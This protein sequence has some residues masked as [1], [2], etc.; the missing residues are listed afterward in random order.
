MT[1]PMEAPKTPWPRLVEL[2]L[3][4]VLFA[5]AYTQRPLFT[6]NQVTKFLHGL[7][8]AGHGHLADD[9]LATTFNT[10][11]PFTWLVTLIYKIHPL[12]FHAAMV[13]I[14][15][16]YL[17]GLVGIA[18]SLGL[19]TAGRLRRWTFLTLVLA[20]HSALAV[21]VVKLLTG[22]EEKG[23][24]GGL[25]EQYL[26]G[27]IFQPNV[28]G[29]FIIAAIAAFASR[30]PVVAAALLA[31]APVMHPTYLIGAGIVLAV[32]L[33]TLLLRDRDWKRALA[34]AGVFLL[35]IV[36]LLVFVSINLA[37]TD[38]ATQARA[39]EILAHSRIE[40]HS[41]PSF[42]DPITIGKG[43]VCLLAIALAWRSVA[44]WVLVAGFVVGGALTAF[45][46]ITGSDTM[47][48]VAP[49]RVS[50]WVVPLAVG[51]VLTGLTRL[52][53]RGEMPAESQRLAWAGNALTVATCLVASV[54]VQVSIHRGFEA[55]DWV[56][57]MRYV[58]EHKQRGDLLM[59]PPELAEFRVQAGAATLVTWKSHPIKDIEVLA[60]HARVEAA[61]RFYEAPDEPSRE[62]ALRE[63][64]EAY[65]VTH[66]LVPA[67]IP[68]PERFGEVA[69]RDAGYALVRVAR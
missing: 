4:S 65:R 23:F 32:F 27:P 24:P 64:V 40:H 1:A 59:V 19:D 52:I 28:F 49:W 25:A 6:S 21:Q 16:F 39:H 42:L 38:A 43:V 15:A 11:P 2:L 26:I 9:W 44:G 50:V 48:L 69:Y 41:V 35:P 34:A 12:G 53:L 54:L 55:L 10:F 37:P 67:S 18:R 3:W 60:W 17:W 7:A 13:P 61:T 58:R 8:A 36:P 46:V 45:T 57:A 51:I 63:A 14:F 66:V 47:A 56:P 68:Q 22:V 33:G 62:A 30:R 5:V 20:S 31:V 29:V